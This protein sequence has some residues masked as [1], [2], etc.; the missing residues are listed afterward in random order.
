PRAASTPN[1]KIYTQ[2]P[3]GTLDLKALI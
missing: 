2:A 3:F 1:A